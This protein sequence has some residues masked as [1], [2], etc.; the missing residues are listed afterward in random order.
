MLLTQPA[1]FPNP[2][3]GGH[4]EANTGPCYRVV[5]RAREAAEQ[6]TGEMYGGCAVGEFN[7]I[8]MK[9]SDPC[10]FFPSL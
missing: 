4:L 10:K 2:G 1:K 7:L 9:Q 3:T 8:P 5:N 6:Q